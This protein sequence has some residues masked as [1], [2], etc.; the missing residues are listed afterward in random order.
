MIEFHHTYVLTMLSSP[1]QHSQQQQHHRPLLHQHHLPISDLMHSLPDSYDQ[2]SQL[3]CS[4]CTCNLIL[5]NFSSHLISSHLISSQSP[6]VYRCE[7]KLYRSRSARCVPF[8]RL[9]QVLFMQVRRRR[10][11]LHGGLARHHSTPV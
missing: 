3:C 8:L 6:L 5:S 1:N 10:C 7:L 2:S 11:L 9:C 4:N